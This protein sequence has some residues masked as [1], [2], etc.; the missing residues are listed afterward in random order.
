MRLRAFIVVD[1]GVGVKPSPARV[2]PANGSRR[3]VDLGGRVITVGFLLAALAVA[4]QTFAHLMNAFVF[5]YGVWNMDASQ[6]GNA[7]SWASSV[8]T[9]GAALGALLLGLRTAVPAWRLVLLAVVLAFFSLDDVVAIHEKLAFA[10]YGAD[11]PKLIRRAF[12]PV[13]YLPLFAFVTWML[14]QT[15]VR[16]EDRLRRAIQLGVGLLAVALVAEGVATIWWSEDDRERPLVDDLEVA[17][18]E[19]AELV[20]WILIAAA[21]F[22]LL[23]EALPGFHGE[24][25]RSPRAG[26]EGPPR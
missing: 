21:L 14:W 10:D 5:D 11:I 20:A 25:E 6:D 16:A 15:A 12:W 26:E 23:C 19:G 24:I 13:L 18:E 22:A 3:A 2:T 7:F 17:I 8:A 9:F 4:V 1:V